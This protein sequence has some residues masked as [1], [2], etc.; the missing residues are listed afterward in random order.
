MPGPAFTTGESVS[1]HPI[2]P[3]D[4]EFVQRERQHPSA[5]VPLSASQIRTREEIAERFGE[6]DYHYLVCVDEWSE[7]TEQASGEERPASS[8]DERSESTDEASGEERPA[9]SV[10]ERSESTDEASGEE[11]PASSESESTDDATP[12]RV[13]GVAL[14]RTDGTSGNLTYWIARDHRGQGY[15]TAATELLLDFVFRECG[16]HKVTA[17]TFVSNEP[18]VRTLESLGFEREGRLR[19]AGRL[20]GEFEDMYQYSVLRRE[21]LED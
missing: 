9:S 5:R 2:E 6:T 1:L 7:S 16:F 15:V 4:Y 21:W 8:V 17:N 19:E 13:G 3:E 18:S 12:E 11:R 20:D 14:T 10:D